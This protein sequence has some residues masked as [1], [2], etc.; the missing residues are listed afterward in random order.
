MYDQEYNYVFS[1]S[2]YKVRSKK[3]ISIKTNC[4]VL[5]KFKLIHKKDTFYNKNK[6]YN[7][8]EIQTHTQKDTFYYKY[9]L[10]KYQK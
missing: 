7:I 9:L 10:N 3:L 6:V 1:M 4:R 2:F 8:D 5:K